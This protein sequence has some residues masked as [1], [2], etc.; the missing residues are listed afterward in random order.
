MLSI[1]RKLDI[2]TRSVE[3]ASSQV[4]WTVE[5]QVQ[6]NGYRI[7]CERP[8]DTSVGIASMATHLHAR[9]NARGNYQILLSIEMQEVGAIQFAENVSI[10]CAR[11]VDKV[12]ERYAHYTQIC[13]TRRTRALHARRWWRVGSN[14]NRVHNVGRPS[15]RIST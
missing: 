14:R 8:K 2:T 12:A 4:A 15:R 11:N 9:A 10:R 5:S 13:R 7:P 1:K 3:S 6:K